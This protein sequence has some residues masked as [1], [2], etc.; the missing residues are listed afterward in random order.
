MTRWGEPFIIV[1]VS[2]VFVF[3]N[4]MKHM[5]QGRTSHITSYWRVESETGVFGIPLTT[6]VEWDQKRVNN[7]AL[8]VPL[9]LEDIITF[10]LENAI[11][12]EGILRKSGSSARIK[13][14]KQVGDAFVTEGHKCGL[15]LLLQVPYHGFS[16]ESK[17]MGQSPVSLQS[18]AMHSL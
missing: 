7:P 2:V 13:A 10:L 4:V 15:A 12:D 8:R 14:L 17:R 9:V 11:E 16:E 6:L 5:L 18:A 3:V 1:A